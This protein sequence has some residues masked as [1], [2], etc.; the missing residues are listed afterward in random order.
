MEKRT[1]SALLALGLLF[2]TTY[3]VSA[4]PLT[5]EQQK[6]LQ[7]NKEKLNEVNNKIKTLNDKIDDLTAKIEPIVWE[8]EEN[9]DKIKD[10]NGQIDVIGTEIDSAKEKLVEKQ[11][12]FGDRMRAIYKSGGNTSYLSIILS[13]ESLGDMIDKIQAVGKIMK[14][15]K[16][17]ISD[18]QEQKDILDS[19]VKELQD[20]ENEIVEINAQNQKKIDEMN[21]LKEQQLKDI[22]ELN[23][24]KKKIV[25]D[26][27]ESERPMIEYP[28]SIIK[29]SSPS[30]SELNSA[31]SM[32]RTIRTQIQTDKIDAECVK[33]IEKAKDM[34]KAKEEPSK[35][36]TPVINRGE[37][38]ASGSASSLLSYAYRFIGVP[39]SYGATGPNRFD[40]S[41]FTSYVYRHALGME[42][43]RTTYAQIG[44]GTPVSYSNLRPGDLVF[45]NGVGHVGIYV[46]NGQMIHAPRTGENVKVGPIYHFSGA[47]RLLK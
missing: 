31:I 32:L 9:E 41:G 17:V 4:D 5:S 3:N 28:I 12:A 20:K 46:G 16:A 25:V 36:S 27:A 47:R 42:I 24:E 44:R 1:I 39:Y 37:E 21:V 18:I 29:K 14:I 30:I 8:V 22:K 33:Y 43:G 40:C 35:P 26:L 2:G 7:Q 13:S 45:T 34:I 19:K 11:E 23:E 10:I 15:D 38:L 6:E